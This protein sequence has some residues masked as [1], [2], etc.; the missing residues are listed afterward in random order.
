MVLKSK[1]LKSHFCVKC[2]LESN[3]L[4]ENLCA[5]CYL[6][7][8]NVKV[9]KQ[10]ELRLCSTCGNVLV[11]HFWIKPN[12]EVRDAFAEQVAKAITTP[13]EIKIL[14]VDLIKIKPNGSAEVT[15][16]IGTTIL[17]K[18]YTMFLKIQKQLC[19]TCKLKLSTSSKAIVQLRADDDVKTFISDSLYFLK[20]YRKH[21]VQ[22]TE[23][24]RG[25]DVHLR[26]RVTALSLARNFKQKFPCHMKET[27]EEYGWERSRVR[28]KYKSTILLTKR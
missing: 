25:L 3:K 24:R 21:I 23:V 1:K 12:K 14:K 6:S 5:E 13:E 8:H 16:Q 27:R 28:P 7:I 20:N 19:P 10:K 17:S 2:G 22:I 15:Y 9:P 11:N 18:T 26:G 4:T